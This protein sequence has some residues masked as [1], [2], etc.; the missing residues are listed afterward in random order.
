MHRLH[1]TE[2]S[3][4]T[5]YIQ[6]ADLQV[7]SQTFGLKFGIKFGFQIIQIVCKSLGLLQ[8]HSL[9]WNLFWS[10]FFPELSGSNRLSQTV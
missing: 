2:F 10:T 9:H 1:S 7:K 3:S 8:T 4:Y 5:G 6:N